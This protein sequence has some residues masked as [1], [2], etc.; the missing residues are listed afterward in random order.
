MGARGS[1]FWVEGFTINTSKSATV[2][3][4]KT[5]LRPIRSKIKGQK[6]EMEPDYKAGKGMR[7]FY[8]GVELTYRLPICRRPKD[9]LK[10]RG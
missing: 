9:S 2:T 4:S 8:T 7:V 6:V 3:N 10:P 5:M 1:Q